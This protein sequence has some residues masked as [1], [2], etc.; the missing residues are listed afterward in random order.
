MRKYDLETRT[1]DNISVQENNSAFPPNHFN[2]LSEF[3]QASITYI[4]GYVAKMTEKKTYCM[5]CCQAL[6]SSAHKPE[7]SFLLVKDRG[8]IFKPTKSV[9]TVC[10]ETECFQWIMKV[11]DG[12]LPHCKGIVDA[13]AVSVLGGINHLKIFKELHNHMFDTPVN[14]NHIISL[15]K[16]ISK[17]YCKVKLY[18]LG[19]EA[20]A[21]LQGK[22]TLGNYR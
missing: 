11:T 8:S 3:K 1:Q 14:D 4:A 13:I 6:G 10:E 15:I 7:S 2:N 18:H 22:N 12:K 21:K 19:K 5:P 20:T 17:C 9:I 16:N